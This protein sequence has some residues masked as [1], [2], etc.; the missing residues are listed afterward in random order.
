MPD[1][2][3]YYPENEEAELYTRIIT[4]SSF[5]KLYINTLEELNQQ[6]EPMV[7]HIPPE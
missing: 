7:A 5:A 1:F 2:D 6:Y 4:S 3:Q